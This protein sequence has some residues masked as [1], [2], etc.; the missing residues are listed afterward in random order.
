MTVLQTAATDPVTG[1]TPSR[2]C[3]RVTVF[4]DDYGIETQERHYTETVDDATVVSSGTWMFDDEDRS[5]E[6]LHLPALD[7]DVPIFVVDTDSETQV[8]LNI[9][10]RRRQIRKLNQMLVDLGLSTR[11]PAPR[12]LSPKFRRAQWDAAR[13]ACR[14]SAMLTDV[15]AS[16]GPNF[17]G[18]F[19]SLVEVAESTTDEATLLAPALA[20]PW[21][22]HL[23]CPVR[24]LNSTHNY[25][26]YLEHLL[27]W[28]AY[29]ALLKLLAKAGII[30]K[31][32]YHAS[33]ARK[34]THLR[35]PWIH[36]SG[37]GGAEM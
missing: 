14:D 17:N 26:L 8:W 4:Q 37:S 11:Q 15:M 21:V 24:V 12:E 35:L 9:K 25:H 13:P 7:I 16:L 30:E 18:D 22:L 29:K 32:Y 36:K 34:A 27:G 6:P 28:E 2:R 5:P 31:G 3:F 20:S 10:P 1:Q 19:A 33:V 23:S